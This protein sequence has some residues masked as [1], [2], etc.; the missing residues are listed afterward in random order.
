MGTKKVSAGLIMYKVTDEKLKVFLIHPGGPFWKNKDF[1]AWSIPKGEPDE[2][3]KDLLAVARREFDE[4]IGVASPTEK[5]KYISLGDITQKS[6]KV[7]HAWAFEGDWNGLLMCRS[8]VDVEWPEK[9]RKIIKI[10]EVDRA[11][12][13]SIENTKERI[14]PAQFELVERLIEKLTLH[15]KV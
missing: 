9:S 10:P 5:E 3:E 8:F 14:N 11:G 6:G 2:G 15:Q 1:G 13:F 4:E 7:V 12:F